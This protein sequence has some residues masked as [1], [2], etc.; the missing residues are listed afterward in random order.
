[1]VVLGEQHRETLRARLILTNCYLGQGR[2]DEAENECTQVVNG[3]K[4]TLKERHS[5]TLWSMHKL[6]YIYEAQGDWTK[7]L[8]FRE[9]TLEIQEQKD[10]LGEDSRATQESMDYLACA[11]YR[12]GRVQEATCLMER[13]LRLKRKRLVKVPNS[14]SI[15]ASAEAL[16]EWRKAEK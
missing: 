6:A 15:L 12:K 16:E 13:V 14:P 7:L 11:L 9:R 10:V 8:V 5:H 4:E 3:R 1:M 2:L